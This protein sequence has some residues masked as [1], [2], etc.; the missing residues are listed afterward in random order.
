MDPPGIRLRR[1]RTKIRIGRAEAS[2]R[3]G[4]A[5]RTLEAWEQGRYEPGSAHRERILSVLR[6]RHEAVPDLLDAAE[7]MKQAIVLLE[8]ASALHGRIGLRLKPE[9][10]RLISLLRNGSEQLIEVVERS[11]GAG[12]VL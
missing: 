11:P 8:R 12:H 6:G 9:L 3:L 10:A 1:W 4:V 5:K 7:H 2:K